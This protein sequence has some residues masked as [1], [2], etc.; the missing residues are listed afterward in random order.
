MMS[1]YGMSMTPMTYS[2]DQLHL[3]ADFDAANQLAV[4]MTKTPFARRMTT[5]STHSTILL[6]MDTVA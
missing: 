2:V 5:S 6:D 1:T 3:P 4:L